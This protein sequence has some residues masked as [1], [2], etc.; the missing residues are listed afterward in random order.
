[1]S[2]LGDRPG[3]YPVSPWTHETRIEEEVGRRQGRVAD[4]SRFSEARRKLAGEGRVRVSRGGRQGGVLRPRRGC[5]H[6]PG[7]GCRALA[8]W[9]RGSL[10][11]SAAP[12]LVHETVASMEDQGIHFGGHLATQEVG[13]DSPT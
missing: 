1:M 13:T 2:H 12:T 11:S 6:G 10:D 9:V 3:E 7:T 4:I 5:C 8:G